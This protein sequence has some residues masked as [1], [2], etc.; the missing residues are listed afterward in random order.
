MSGFNYLKG[1]IFGGSSGS[2][3]PIKNESIEET[4]SES[5]KKSTKNDF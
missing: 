4:G 3:E 5:I 1:K 2:T